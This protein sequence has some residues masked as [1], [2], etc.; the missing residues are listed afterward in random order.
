V[1]IFKRLLHKHKWE[2]KFE[3]LWTTLYILCSVGHVGAVFDVIEKGLVGKG[4]IRA[5]FVQCSECEQYKLGTNIGSSVLRSHV[6]PEKIRRMAEG[7][8]EGRTDRDEWNPLNRPYRVG[9]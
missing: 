3:D 5:Y 7:Y 1:N 2:L 8:W 9:L 4:K 6:S